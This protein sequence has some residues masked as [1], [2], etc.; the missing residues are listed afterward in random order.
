MHTIPAPLQP[1]AAYRQFILWTK[2]ERDG[3]LVKLPVD[4]HTAQVCDPHNPSCWTDAQTAC[5][6]ASFF[7][8]DYGVGFVFTNRDPFFF[9]DID[10]CW[11]GVAWS[12]QAQAL[13][14]MFPGA[15][16]EVSQ[17]GTGLH[18][19]GTGTMPEHACK[20][21]GLDLELYH[22]KRFVAL[23]GINV[24]GSADTDCTFGLSQVVPYYFP[25]SLADPV[26][27]TDKPEAGWCP[28]DMTEIITKASTQQSAASVFGVKAT[29]SDLFYRNVE[30]LALAYPSQNS[31]SMYDESS[32]DAA[33]ASHLAFWC[34]KNC[35]MVWEIMW[36]SALVRDKWQRKDYLARTVSRAVAAQQNIYTGGQRQQQQQQAPTLT[37]EQVAQAQQQACAAGAEF[38]AGVQVLTVT[39]QTEYFKGCVYVRDIHRVFTPDGALLKPEQ[40]KVQYGGFNFMLDAEGTKQTRN[41]WEAFTESLTVRW[42][43]VTSTCFRP[44]LQQGAIIE[45]EGNTLVNTYVPVP[46]NA[47]QG[48]VTPFLNHMQ[49]MLPE[50]RDRDILIAYMAACVQHPGI[51]FQWAPL[52]QGCEGNGKSLVIRAIANAV[53]NRY[54]HLPNAADLG[55]NGAKFNAWIQNKLFIGVEEIHVG[56]KREIA[57]ALKP[58][59][60]NS[61]I[62]IQGKGTDQI[63]GD[64]RANFILCSNHKD[65]VRKTANDRRYCVLYTAQ[66]ESADM[67][68]LSRSY[69]P[70]LYNWLNA[71]GYANVT[72]FLKTYAIPDELNPAKLCHRAPETSSTGEAIQASLGSIEQEILEAIEEGRYGFA[73]GWISSM[74]LDRLLDD[75]R[76]SRQIPRNKR[77]DLLKSLGYDYHPGLK[78]GRTSC[79]IPLDNG[80]PRLFIKCG[81]LAC[82]LQYPHDVVQAYTKAQEQGSNENTQAQAVFGRGGK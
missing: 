39:Q 4:P 2:A 48:D 11:D 45:E 7:G 46:T 21:T 82:N 32:A 26:R 70:D 63:T 25:M 30:K 17:S 35:Q 57:D 10:H 59:I 58:L 8:P 72:Y 28:M 68:G 54:T 42:P 15:A 31:V 78:E 6:H 16:M 69:F 62:E 18:I 60:T 64:N 37:V 49:F 14:A 55:G 3:K 43:K 19:F 56:D 9:L 65:A 47:T 52:I 44:E 61:R 13:C 1:M 27:W 77:R 53:G 71:G 23:T 20:N 34:G 66:Q 33:L 40:F 75:L 36:M 22:E 51:K 76:A 73:G 74:A 12:Q 81:H 79:I 67:A 24:V 38:A 5:T 80:K 41:A 29:F 50:H